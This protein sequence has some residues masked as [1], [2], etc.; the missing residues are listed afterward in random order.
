VERGG[1][2]ERRPA[3]EQIGL[4]ALSGHRNTADANALPDND[5]MPLPCCHLNERLRDTGSQARQPRKSVT[6][7]VTQ[8]MEHKPACP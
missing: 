2:L 3:D 6:Q 4:S 1:P 8:S 7:V 5:F